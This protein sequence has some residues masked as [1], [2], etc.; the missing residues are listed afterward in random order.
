[1]MVLVFGMFTVWHKVQEPLCC[2]NGFQYNAVNK[3]SEC[4]EFRDF[5][6]SDDYPDAF[7]PGDENEE[8]DNEDLW[9]PFYNEDVE[10]SKWN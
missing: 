4:Y 3:E 2:V 1:M 7:E 6:P 9:P 8:D 10:E 5:Q